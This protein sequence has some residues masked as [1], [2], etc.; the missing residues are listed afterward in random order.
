MRSGRWLCLALCLTATRL[1]H[2]QTVVPA[3]RS[4]EPARRAKT[5]RLEFLHTELSELSVDYCDEAAMEFEPVL[6][7]LS[8]ERTAQK[9]WLYVRPVGI[10]S[11][12]DARS[13]VIE[14]L[15]YEI[16]QV[17][18]LP[19]TMTTRVRVHFYDGNE[20]VGD[21]EWPRRSEDF[22]ADL[23]LKQRLESWLK[24]KAMAD[25]I[26]PT[27]FQGSLFTV[28]RIYTLNDGV[29]DTSLWISPKSLADNPL[30]SD[31]T[32]ARLSALLSPRP[33]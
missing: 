7:N 12:L 21:Y 31:T 24:S 25:G 5:T 30:I 17:E 27:G 14:V 9:V 32:R 10:Q 20:I 3:A 2:A 11:C 16:S 23:R 19:S 29:V 33:R 13:P 1:I 6:K 18:L 26:L 15:P 22:T 4:S 28:W 8:Q